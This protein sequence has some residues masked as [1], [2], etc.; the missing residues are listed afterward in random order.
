MSMEHHTPEI[1]PE[2][3][4]SSSLSDFFYIP[5]PYPK[6]VYPGAFPDPDAFTTPSE[7]DKNAL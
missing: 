3:L 6:P 4:V 1:R 5:I 7:A 2:R